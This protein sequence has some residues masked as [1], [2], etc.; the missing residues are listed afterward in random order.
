MRLTI[1]IY[2]R[3]DPDLLA[4]Y[5]VSGKEFDIKTEIKTSLKNYLSNNVIKKELP[6]MTCQEMFE[7]PPKVNFHIALKKDEDADIIEWLKTI[8]QGRRNNLIKNIYRN[9]IPPVI[10]PYYTES[11]TDPFK[12]NERRK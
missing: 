1:R 3:H 7:L 6:E 4:L 9:S 2:K 8:K 5:F 12:I 10:A 11:E